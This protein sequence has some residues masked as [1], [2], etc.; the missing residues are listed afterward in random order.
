MSLLATES[1]L[2]VF[3][4][5]FMLILVFFAHRSNF[6]AV[7][8]ATL[9]AYHIFSD[10]S[11]LLRIRAELSEHFDSPSSLE[12]SDPKRLHQLPLLSGVYA[13]VLRLYVEVFF[14]AS[15][16][17][18]DV[19][20]GRWILPRRCTGIVS[21]SISHRDTDFWNTKGEL[22]PLNTFWAERFILDPHDPTSG[23]IRPDRRP[24]VGKRAANEGSGSRKLSCSTSGL[25][26]SWIPYGGEHSTCCRVNMR[27]NK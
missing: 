7:S 15:S 13:E 21:T 20:L 5:T 27:S 2:C 12:D 23:P 26:G 9:A 3:M 19:L 10:S 6:N 17:H 16:P 14:M 18:D 8:A 11:L 25:R 24:I 4:I 22:H 1:F